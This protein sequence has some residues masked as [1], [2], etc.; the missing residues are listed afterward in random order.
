ME[1][2]GAHILGYSMLCESR[3]SRGAYEYGCYLFPNDLVRISFNVREKRLSSY[4]LDE[5]LVSKQRA[6]MVFIGKIGVAQLCEQGEIG[7]QLGK[8]RIA[9]QP[10]GSTSLDVSLLFRLGYIGTGPSS[11]LQLSAPGFTRHLARLASVTLHSRSSNTDEVAPPIGVLEDGRRYFR[12]PYF[13]FTDDFTTM[14]GRGGS[15]GGCY[16]APMV[17][18]E[19]GRR[20]VRGVR[21]LGL[22]PPGVSS[23]TVLLRVVEDVVQSCTEGVE[24]SLSD[25]SKMVI[26]LDLVAYIGDYPGMVECLDLMGH[27]ALAPC[28]HCVF[29]RADV[30]REEE[31]SRY[32]YNP[33]VNSADPTFRRTKTR[34]RLIREAAGDDDAQLKY[35][36]LKEL[37]SNALQGLPL[38][39]LSDRLEQVQNQIPRTADGLPVVSARF[40]PYMSHA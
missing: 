14:G 6:A 24:I 22:T 36:G 5:E 35:Y 9:V 26:F 7:D 28:T 31:N 19:S 34:M 27:N 11:I 13:L 10:E 37:S 2:N 21:V 25:G 18:P 38:H 23:N 32:A 29:I 30:E 15:S 40:D 3:I 1:K 8:I 4:L 33:S 17:V 39:R 12:I 20:S 16:L